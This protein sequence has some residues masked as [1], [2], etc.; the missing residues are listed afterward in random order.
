MS[1][2][3]K[4]ASLLSWNYKYKLATFAHQDIFSEGNT[5]KLLKRRNSTYSLRGSNKLVIPRPRTDILRKS[6]TYRASTLWNN[7][8]DSTTTVSDIN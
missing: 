5:N 2:C 8:N 6:I 4:V 7:L 1:W 3:A